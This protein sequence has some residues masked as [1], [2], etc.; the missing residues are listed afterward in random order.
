MHEQT[1]KANSVKL[2]GKV[3]LRRGKCQM[4]RL[5][6]EISNRCYIYSMASPY[7]YFTDRIFTFGKYFEKLGTSKST[8][9]L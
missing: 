6:R 9:L 2:N 7:R 5:V 3:Y 8:N 4:S 1:N